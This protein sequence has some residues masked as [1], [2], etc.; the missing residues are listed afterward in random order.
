M[1][2]QDLKRLVLQAW[3]TLYKYRPHN[4]SLKI[5]LKEHGHQTDLRLKS[6]WRALYKQFCEKG[7]AFDEQISEQDV[8]TVV[9]NLLVKTKGWFHF[10]EIVKVFPNI[11]KETLHRW[12]IKWEKEDWFYLSTLGN[13][14]WLYPQYMQDWGISADP[15]G[16]WGIKYQFVWQPDRDQKIA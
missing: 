13:C 1:T 9:K 12:L 7:T 16:F 6:V 3:E 5:W 2:I 10:Y 15:T 8:K 14:N 4:Q 11:D